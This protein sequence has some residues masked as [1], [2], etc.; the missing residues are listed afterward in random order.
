LRNFFIRQ[1]TP[2]PTFGHPPVPPWAFPSPPE[3]PKG[4]QS[5]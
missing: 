1:Y 2:A 3:R 4:E 5:N